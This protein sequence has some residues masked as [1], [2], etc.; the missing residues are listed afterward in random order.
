MILNNKPLLFSQPV[1]DIYVYRE[2]KSAL[3]KIVHQ[4]TSICDKKKGSIDNLMTTPYAH[5]GVT[6]LYDEIT[7]RHLLKQ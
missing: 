2:I 1:L 6:K 3:V 7:H 5:S 4:N